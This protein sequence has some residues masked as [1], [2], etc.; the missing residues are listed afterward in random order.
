MKFSKELLCSLD[1]Y[2]SDNY[3][4]EDFIVECD[5]DI[6]KSISLKNERSLDELVNNIDETFSKMLLRL[7]D[8][9]G[10]KDSE[11][12]KKANVDRRLFSKIKSNIDYNPKKKTVIAFALALELS[13]DETNDLLL[14]AGYALSN[15][16]KFDVIIEFFI[17]NKIYDI[18][19]INE[20]LLKYEVPIIE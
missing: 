13:L 7:I 19:E 16:R 12:Y 11:V 6:C 17:E 9:R 15:S 1:K 20:V 10:L 3:I 18:F 4:N 2:I 14:K 5:E 8:E